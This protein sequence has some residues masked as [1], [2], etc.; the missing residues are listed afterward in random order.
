MTKSAA[1]SL[2]FGFP[3]SLLG[4]RMLSMTKDESSNDVS[5]PAKGCSIYEAWRRLLPDELAAATEAQKAWASAGGGRRRTI[6]GGID[7]DSTCFGERERQIRRLKNEWSLAG[8]KCLSPFIQWLC[9]GTYV[10]L[11]SKDSPTNLPTPIR[12]PAWQDIR[13]VNA[14]K[15]IV[16]ERTRAK[17]R[18]YGVTIYPRSLAPDTKGWVA[19]GQSAAA[20]ATAKDSDGF[21]MKPTTNDRVLPVTTRRKQTPKQKSIREAVKGL[22]SGADWKFLSMKERISR[23]KDWLADN[24]LKP[25]SE[26]TISRHFAQSGRR[27]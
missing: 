27:K 18:W 7:H 23:I 4:G 19:V 10:A 1:D 11:G 5:W 8:Q 16:E 22:R 9:E 2:A 26:A 25:A 21:H 14:H 20:I 6:F 3:C 15:S 24:G 13:I 17:T 12:G